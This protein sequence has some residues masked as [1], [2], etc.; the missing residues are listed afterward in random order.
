VR[1]TEMKKDWRER[2]KG[3]YKKTMEDEM[4]RSER[5]GRVRKNKAS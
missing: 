4:R 1:I 2:E 5:M 3:R